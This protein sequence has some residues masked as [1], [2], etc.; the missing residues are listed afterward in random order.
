MV[1]LLQVYQFQIICIKGL[2]NTAADLLSRNPVVL[3]IDNNSNYWFTQQQQDDNLKLLIWRF[4]NQHCT[5]R[6]IEST[7]GISYGSY[8]NFIEGFMGVHADK[9]S[10]PSTIEEFRQ[11][12]EDFEYLDGEFGKQLLP[13]VIGAAGGKLNN[14]YRPKQDSESYRDRKSNLPINLIDVCDSNCRFLY[15][16]AGES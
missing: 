1:L 2:S 14:I 4:A 5:F 13:D 9:I 12:K 6:V 15:I 11:V 8:H 3:A 16:Y 7:H 10:W